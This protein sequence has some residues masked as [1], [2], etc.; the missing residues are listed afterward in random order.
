MTNY[1]K[2]QAAQQ[3]YFKYVAMRQTLDSVL[4]FLRRTKRHAQKD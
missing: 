4:A 2:T 1:P 3:E